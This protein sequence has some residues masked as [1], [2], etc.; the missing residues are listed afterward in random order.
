MHFLTVSICLC[1]FDE[2][3]FVPVKKAEE[4][5]APIDSTDLHGAFLEGLEDRRCEE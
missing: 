1:D 2:W 5:T 4:S 3:S